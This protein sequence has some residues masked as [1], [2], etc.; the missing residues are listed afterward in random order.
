MIN[1][2]ALGLAY[3]ATPFSKYPLGTA[4]AYRD[5]ARLAADL[6][7]RGVKVYSPIAHSY[8]LALYGNIDPCDHSIW[9]PFDEAMMSVAQ[10]LIVAHMQGWEES[11]GI[12]EEVRFFEKAGKP[13]FDLDPETFMM[14]RRR[15]EPAEA[16]GA[17]L[18]HLARGTKETL[19]DA[20]AA[21]ENEFPALRREQ[22]G[23]SA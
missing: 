17:L 1:T 3:L 19:R 6:M 15:D 8:P 7:L 5:A 14:V 18:K 20:V 9:M 4:R 21:L 11:Y 16:R 10:V 22:G 13:I 12:A 2:S 23:S